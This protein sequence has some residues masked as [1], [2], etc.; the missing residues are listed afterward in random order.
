MRSDSLGKKW[1]DRK[2]N[3]ETLAVSAVMRAIS[4]TKHLIP[5]FNANEKEPIWDGYV[6]VYSSATYTVNSLCR[7]VNVQ[8]KG[9]SGATDKET[10]SYPVRLVDLE[11]YQNDNP[12]A[13]F[14]VRMDDK[15]EAVYYA[16]FACNMS[17]I[18]VQSHSGQETVSVKLEKLPAESEAVERLFFDLIGGVAA[19]PE[20]VTWNQPLS[21]TEV[22]LYNADVVG[23][24]GRDR[25]LERLSTFLTSP[26][27]FRWWGVTAPGG[28][29]KS[30]LGY[31]WGNRV[32]DRGWT[33]ILLK[34]ENYKNLSKVTNK[35]LEPLLLIA[36]YARQHTK[37]LGEWMETLCDTEREHPVRLLL[38]ERDEGIDASGETPWEKE[39][40]LAGN[41]VLLRRARHEKLLRLP[42]MENEALRKV[43]LSFSSALQKRD[44]TLPALTETQA[45]ELVQKLSEIDADFRRPLYA[46]I[47]TDNF[48]RDPLAANWTREE[49]LTELVTREQ[50]QLKRTVMSLQPARERLDT[51]LYNAVLALRRLATALGASGDRELK[52]LLALDQKLSALIKKKAEQYKLGSVEELLLYL[53]LLQSDQER[54][55]VPALRP[56]LLGEY[57]VLHWILTCRQDEKR[58]FYAVALHDREVCTFYQRLCINYAPL[59]NGDPKR[60]QTLLPET[61]MEAD[62]CALHYSFLVYYSFDCCSNREQRELLSDLGIYLVS[63]LSI[64]NLTAA[65]ISKNLVIMLIAEGKY[66]EAYTYVEKEL[67]VFQNIKKVKSYKKDKTLE[68]VYA[69]FFDNAGH[70]VMAESKDIYQALKFYREALDIRE[71]SDASIIEKAI[72]YCNLGVYYYRTG[73]YSTAKDYQLKA[74]AVRETYLG[75]QNRETAVSYDELGLVYIATH[76]NKRAE[77]HLKIALEIREKV[78]NPQHPD[79]ATSY[80]NLGLVYEAMGDYP[81]SLEYYQKALAIYVKTLGEKHPDT[82][83]SYNNLGALYHN[84][85]GYDRAREHYQKALAICE[86]T[87]GSEHPDTAMSYINLGT[88]HH[89]MGDYPH[90]LEHYQK[91]L[92]IC[93]KT[94]GGEHL[95]T[96]MCCNNLGAL[97]FHMGDY[98]KAKEYMKRAVAIRE[99]ALGSQQ[100]NTKASREWLKAINAALSESSDA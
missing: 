8:I 60:W 35:H 46:M 52:E 23:F 6:G 72:S 41:E 88:V 74:L 31:E 91:A 83:T 85:G 55:L 99:H 89:A 5:F 30:R 42:S 1:G 44:D 87:L 17:K 14:V 33:V 71:S 66:M 56:D 100:P 70:I 97:Y 28:A 7:R 92:A 94:L 3:T 68:L 15:N 24:Y 26:G 58:D 10:I 93:E 48:L 77:I 98:P 78:L 27:M 50:E 96:A 79:L 45:G 86:K 54:W 63:N 2:M 16:L 82:A 59:L 11:H 65:T 57:A 67:T 75:R 39:L 25:E 36:D 69:S 61:P 49:L 37:T 32:R 20:I 80:N 84:M 21:D 18:F 90:A 19:A 64:N 76:D 43:I 13:F 40:Y 53:G 81:R 9:Q 47:L 12:T 29:G 22:F 4:R 38:L 62:D 95:D 73:Q 34:A 51:G